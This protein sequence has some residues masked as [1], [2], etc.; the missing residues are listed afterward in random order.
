MKVRDEEKDKS[1]TYHYKLASL[2]SYSWRAK[3]STNSFLQIEF[4]GKRTVT[5]ISTQGYGQEI[6]L[7]YK[8]RYQKGG[9]DWD[10]YK[11]NGIEK[12]CIYLCDIYL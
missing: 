6:V 3:T 7:T 8:V 4:H 2:F 12:V 5:G 11:E 9:L 1:F 10:F